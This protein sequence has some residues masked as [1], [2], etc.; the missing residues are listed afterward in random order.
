MVEGLKGVPES[1]EDYFR[2]EEIE[3]VYCEPCDQNTLQTK[4]PKLTRLPPVLTFNLN[5]IK[6]DMTTFDRIKI[7]DRFEYPMELDLSKF[8]AQTEEA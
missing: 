6:Y 8:L 5:R 2:P 3:G 7:N 1:L 4:G